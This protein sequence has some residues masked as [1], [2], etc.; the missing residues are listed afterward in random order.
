MERGLGPEGAAGGVVASAGEDVAAFGALDGGDFAA[1][2][3][4]FVGREQAARG[5]GGGELAGGGIVGGDGFASAARSADEDFAHGAAG[6]VGDGDGF[7]VAAVG[8]GARA[9]GS[10]GSVIGG[11]CGLVA[12]GINARDGALAAL[13]V[14]GVGRGAEAGLAT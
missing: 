8:D 12:V 7:V 6:G 1:G 9:A 4:V 11:R 3:V 13:S 10:I 2:G 14:V 5:E